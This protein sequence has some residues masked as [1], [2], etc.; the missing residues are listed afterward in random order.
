VPA[1][2]TQVCSTCL[3]IDIE[4]PPIP[5]DGYKRAGS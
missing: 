3:M 2:N 4:M 5:N 1:P